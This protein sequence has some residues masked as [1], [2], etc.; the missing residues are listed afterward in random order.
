MEKNIY[1][2]GGHRNIRTRN[3][4]YCADCN[5][6]PLVYKHNKTCY[7]KHRIGG[8]NTRKILQHRYKTHVRHLPYQ[9]LNSSTN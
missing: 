4:S 2:T 3:S 8:Q 1:K 5:N 9:T 7:T 6:H